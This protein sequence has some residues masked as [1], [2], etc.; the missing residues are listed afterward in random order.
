[1][2]GIPGHLNGH[3]RDAANEQFLSYLAPSPRCSGVVPVAAPAPADAQRRRGRRARKD[4]ITLRRGTVLKNRVARSLIPASGFWR[5]NII[6]RHMIRIGCCCCCCCFIVAR[7]LACFLLAINHESVRSPVHRFA[8]LFDHLLHYSMCVRDRDQYDIYYLSVP[9]NVL[10]IERAGRKVGFRKF[11][12]LDTRLCSLSVCSPQLLWWNSTT[13]DSLTHTDEPPGLAVIMRRT[14]NS[15]GVCDN[16][17]FI[18][19]TTSTRARCVS[20]E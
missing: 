8:I 20:A 6:I 17:L 3:C 2:I 14:S 12:K 19:N 7:R 18:N 15:S 11:I 9:W 13:Q 4:A 16:S 10:V 1:M 5:A